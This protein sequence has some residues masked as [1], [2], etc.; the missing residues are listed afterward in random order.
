MAISFTADEIRKVIV[1]KKTNKSLRCDEISVELTKYA[2]ETI[3]EQIAEIYNTMT[4]TDD[5]PREITHGILKP[6]HKP[7]KVKAPPSNLRTII[8]FTSLHKILAAW[9]ISRIKDRLDAEIPPSQAVY[10]SNLSTT[11]HIFTCKL[12]IERTITARDEWV[13][14]TKLDASKTYDCINRNKL[15]EDLRITIETEELHRATYHSKLVD[16]S[17]SVRCGNTLS[18]VFE[19]DTG[20]L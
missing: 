8:L 10:K 6:L 14:L 19:R 7:N 5:T 13:H 12:I 3:H 18:E 20:T 9:I 16:V 11:E 17:L 4:E 1:K 15:I 2:P